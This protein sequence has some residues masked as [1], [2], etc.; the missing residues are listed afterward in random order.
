[1]KCKILLLPRV[2]SWWEC[3]STRGLNKNVVSCLLLPQSPQYYQ[4]CSG[5]QWS[6][7]PVTFLSWLLGSASGSNYSSPESILF[8]LFVIPDC[9]REYKAYEWVWSRLS[10]MYRSMSGRDGFSWKQS[11]SACLAALP[12][13]LRGS[14]SSTGTSRS[15]PSPGATGGSATLARTPAALTGFSALSWPRYWLRQCMW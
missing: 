4:R 11:F 13:L 12:T 10:C 7:F 8:K 2:L 14:A 15:S 5:M 9:G 1:M 6:F 3:S